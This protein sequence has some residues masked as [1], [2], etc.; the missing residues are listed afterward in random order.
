MRKQNRSSSPGNRGGKPNKPTANSGK[1]TT[2]PGSTRAASNRPPREAKPD[3]APPDRPSSASRGPRKPYQSAPGTPEGKPIRKASD[4]S[5]PYRKAEGTAEERPYRPATNEPAKPRRKEEGSPEGR[6]YRKPA[7]GPGKPYRKSEG[8]R[9]S[10]PRKEAIPARAGTRL[11]RYLSQAGIAS[12]RDA[13]ELIANGMVTVNDKVVT[14]MGFMVQRNDVV[15]YAGETLRAEKNVYLLLNKPKGYIS[16]TDDEKARK[17]VMELV[18]GACKER[19]FPVGRLDRPT[20]GLLLFTNDGDLAKKL[21]HP[22]HRVKKIYD[23]VLDK[24]LKA[25]DFDKIMRGLELED[26]LAEVDKL[27]YI[28]GKAKN[29]VGIEI[30]IGRNR[31]VRRIFQ[32]VGYEVVKLDRVYLGGLTKKNLP[33]GRWRFLTP[34][35]VN[36]LKML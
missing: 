19:I 36:N 26:G 34:L 27:A 9:P 22:T 7:G 33:R 30:H 4:R 12:R 24:N 28:E 6:P 35:E 10:R 29:N 5:K 18:A 23:V 11:N 14:E 32:A 8:A 16:T 25:S 3:G 1:R 2:K 31:I 21:T 17:T 20:T 13:D 15:R